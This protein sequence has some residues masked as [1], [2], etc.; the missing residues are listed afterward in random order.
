MGLDSYLYRMP[1][2]KKVT[3]KQVAAIENYFSWKENSA[4]KKYTF[5]EW[6]GTD[7]RTLPGKDARDFYRTYY[8]PHYSKYDVEHKYP[9]NEIMDEIAYWRKANQ[10]HAWFVENVQDGIDDC[11]LYEVYEDDIRELL[12]IC[13]RVVAYSK[14]IDGKV[15]NGYTLSADSKWVPIMEDGKTI[16]DP[17]SAR[18]LLPVC[19]G[20]FFGSEEYDEWYLKDIK[21]T[22]EMCRKIL[23]TTDFETQMLCYHSSW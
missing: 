21:Y 22:L 16:E 9:C 17:S 20:F 4:A 18:E 13:E 19:S 23:E 1:R 10:I 5:K 2:Y 3:P 15:I 12:N 6:S 11:G 7:F 14:L 8:V